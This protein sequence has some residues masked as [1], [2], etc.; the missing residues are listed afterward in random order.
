MLLARLIKS[1]L[2]TA[3]PILDNTHRD[4]YFPSIHEPRWLTFL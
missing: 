2:Y 1:R 3:P 4:A